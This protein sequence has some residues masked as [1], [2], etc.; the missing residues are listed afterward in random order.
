[1]DLHIIGLGLSFT[2]TSFNSMA[3]VV[4]YLWLYAEHKVTPFALSWSKLMKPEPL[5]YYM[6]LALP[7]IAM[8]CAAWWAVE[9]LILLST[10]I[11]TRAVACMVIT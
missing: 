7:S 5:K 9:V 8:I 3:I 4:I 2:I 6:R 10:G 1:M 11:S